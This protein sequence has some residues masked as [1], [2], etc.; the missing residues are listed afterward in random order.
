[1]EVSFVDLNVQY[2][3]LEKEIQSILKKKFNESQ[4]IGGKEVEKFEN[5]FAKYIHVKHAVSLNSGTDALILGT[6]ILDLKPTDEIIIPANTFYAAALAATFNGLK[7]VFIDIDSSDFGTNLEDLKRKINSRTK[8]IIVTHLYGQADKIS[9]IKEIIGKYSK[10]IYLIE[11]S[12]QAHGALYEGKRVGSFGIFSAFSFYPSKNLGAY[13]DGGAL[14][15]NDEKIAKKIKL[16]KEYGQSSKYH[17]VSIGTN[18]R[19]D[20]IQAAILNVK[21][22]Y[23]DKWN[24][25]RQIIATK[26]EELLEDVPQ[27]TLPNRF[28]NR[29][30]IYH[31]YVIRSKERNSL[32]KFLSVSKIKTQIHYPI[33]IHLQKGLSFLKYKKG[34]LPIVER[35]A[36]EILSLPIYPELVDQ[37]I[38]FV[39][40]KIKEFYQ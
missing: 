10:K 6:R 29:R 22:K 3:N 34:D 25:K 33:P 32:Q 9:D 20:T 28:N 40:K 30:S 37:Q 15:T 26:Y 38:H 36:Q 8:A 24:K 39:A 4:F 1:M 19:L 14:T 17:H 31:L 27:V 35:A 16:I 23:L 21:L 13:G 2:K 12:S 11:D 18:S 5:N 7:P